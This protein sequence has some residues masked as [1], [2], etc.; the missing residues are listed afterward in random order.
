MRFQ[1]KE[2]FF[3]RVL[4]RTFEGGDIYPPEGVEVSEDWIEQLSTD[5]NRINRPVLEAIEPQEDDYDEWLETLH[6]DDKCEVE[7][8]KK[9]LMSMSAKDLR[10]FATEE[11]GISLGSRV[12]MDNIASLV[13]KHEFGLNKYM[14]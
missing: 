3:D 4:R 11:L 6:E 10:A 13:V 5:D 2:R 14:R 1:V 7:E 9:E 8:R 12:R